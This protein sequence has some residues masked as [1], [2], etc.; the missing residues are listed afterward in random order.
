MIVFYCNSIHKES[1]DEFL[2]IQQIV[3]KTN[4]IKK[5]RII[6]KNAYNNKS[7][8]YLYTFY[9]IKKSYKFPFII[10]NNIFF[11]TWFYNFTIILIIYFL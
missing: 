7:T 9:F 5:R 3:A 11:V 1:I 4:L 8:D 10:P 6:N 2:L